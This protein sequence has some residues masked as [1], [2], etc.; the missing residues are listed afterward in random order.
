MLLTLLNHWHWLAISI[1][2]FMIEIIFSSGF[3]LWIGLSALIVSIIAWVMPQLTWGIQ[4]LLFAVGSIITFIIWWNYLRPY[5]IATD[6]PKLNR[7]SE[8]YVG[9]IFTLAEPIVNGRGKVKVD[10]T[11]WTVE[12]PDLPLG[13][14]VKIIGTNG[15]LLIVE[16][17]P[18]IEK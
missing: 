5:P 6:D 2:L 1:S 4:L 7:R 10:D 3:V 18:S 9:R 13:T 15:I 17:T 14:R 8:Q 12:G 16:E 11:I